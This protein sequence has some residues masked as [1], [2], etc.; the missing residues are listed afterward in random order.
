MADNLFHGISLEEIAEG[1]VVIQGVRTNVVGLVGTAEKGESNKPYLVRDIKDATTYFGTPEK[2]EDGVANDSDIYTIPRSL[3]AIYEQG[4]PLCVVIKVPVSSVQAPAETPRNDE[5]EDT[6]REIEAVEGN[7]DPQ[8]VERSDI[9]TI[10][11]NIIGSYDPDL[12][13]YTG[14]KLLENI[15]SRPV[16]EDGDGNAVYLPVVPKVLI[17]PEF[18]RNKEVGEALSKAAGK[19][20]AEFLVD[21][22]NDPDDVGLPHGKAI[23]Y[24]SQY[25]GSGD[26]R[27]IACYPYVDMG[28]SIGVVGL[29]APA[30]AVT[31]LTKFSQ[32][33]SSQTIRGIRR[34]TKDVSWSLTEESDANN[35]NNNRIVTVIRRDGFRLWGNRSL[36]GEAENRF[37]WISVRRIADQINDSIIRNHFSALDKNI[38]AAYIQNVLEGVQAYLDGMQRDG[39]ILGGLVFVDPEQNTPNEIKVGEVTFDFE[40][41]PVYP[42]NNIKFRSRMTDRFLTEIFPG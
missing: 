40:F 35:L 3:A 4:N 25:G 36:A 32:P 33:I 22:P 6:G 34:L 14:I 20:R 29:S 13:S 15:E 12:G 37:R 17:A 1:A 7:Q 11:Q 16:G 9:E 18:S 28:G 21:C 23:S 24:A 2:R 26:S 27:G 42:A 41:T 31:A 30:A 10:V 8:P 5:A 38:I 19:L 39:D